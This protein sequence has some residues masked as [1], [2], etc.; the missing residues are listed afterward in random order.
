MHAGSGCTTIHL[1]HRQFARPQLELL[2]G[3]YLGPDLRSILHF[4]PPDDPRINVTAKL[5]LPRGIQLGMGAND[6]SP[7]HAD[8]A[9]GSMTL[10]FEPD[11]THPYTFVDVKAGAA[12]AAGSA[13]M[14]RACMVDAGS[15]LATFAQL[16]LAPGAKQEPLLQSQ[17]LRLGARYTSPALSAGAILSPSQAVL[18]DAWVVSCA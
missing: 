1:L 10:R 11:P 8:P 17:N 3:D 2:F 5:G 18:H 6:A 7:T 13:A 9:V 16:P 12:G 15:G 4:A 14:L